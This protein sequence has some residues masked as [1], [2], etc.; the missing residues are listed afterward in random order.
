[1][2]FKTGFT[3][4]QRRKSDTRKWITMYR[5]LNQAG[6]FP[7]YMCFTLNNVPHNTLLYSI[8]RNSKAHLVV[9]GMLA[10]TG[11]LMCKV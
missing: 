4:K 10:G 3:A 1:M 8:H 9:V 11:T 2:V 6:L 5:Y 7:L